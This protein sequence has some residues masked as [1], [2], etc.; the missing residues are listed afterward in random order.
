MR[1]L[2]SGLEGLFE[3]NPAQVLQARPKDSL[4]L[5]KIFKEMSFGW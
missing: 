3:F 5:G 1:N 2:E 4:L